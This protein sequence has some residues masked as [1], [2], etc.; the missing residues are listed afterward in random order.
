MPSMTESAGAWSR[1]P[2]EAAVPAAEEPWSPEW[3]RLFLRCERCGGVALER[4]RRGVSC[5]AC[6]HTTGIVEP[7]FLECLP[8][9]PGHT[10][11]DPAAAPRGSL[12]A[13][14]QRVRRFYEENPFPN[15]DGYESVGDL[16]S[17]ASRSV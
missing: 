12:D 1:A 11:G 17:R 5:G 9:A 8:D 3:V 2:T 10:G 4:D 15:Y 13:V 14:A 6:G 16:L 7:G